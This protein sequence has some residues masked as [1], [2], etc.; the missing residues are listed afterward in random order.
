MP[1]L[2]P[3]GGL[4]YH[5]RAW[6][7]RRT[8]WAPFHDQVR[9]WLTDWR[10][11]VER[12]VLVGPSGGY[13]LSRQFLERFAGITVLEPDPLARRILARRFPDRRFAWETAPWAPG[14]DAFRGLAERHPGAAFL[15]C[16]LLG[17]ELVGEPAGLERRDWLKHLG[18]DLAGLPWA[19]WHD[20]ASTA[21][22][23]DR[24]GA[25]SLPAAEPLDAL[26]R[27]YWQ[28]GELAI[29]DHDCAGL[30]PAQARQYAIWQLK[31]GRYHLVEWLRMAPE[32]GASPGTATNR[33]ALG[34][35]PG[36]S[37]HQGT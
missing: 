3:S 8:L 16:N 32:R 10:P 7:W 20:L 30:C 12:L 31:P 23:P 17:Q 35:P 9:R 5:L 26:L 27:R 1:I 6:R 13:A 11:Q 14:P 37:S 34:T 29:H 25:V 36:A 15:F 2:H 22:P 21:R 28:G 19:S 33:G 18:A 4:I 24:P